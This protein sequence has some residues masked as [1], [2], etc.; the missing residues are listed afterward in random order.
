KEVHSCSNIISYLEIL[1]NF[2]IKIFAKHFRFYEEVF[3]LLKNYGALQV[4]R[5]DT[6]KNIN[7]LKYLSKISIM[8]QKFT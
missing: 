7:F 3:F 4:T 2:K 5:I 8:T 6:E 1:L